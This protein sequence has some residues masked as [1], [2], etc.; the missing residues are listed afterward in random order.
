MEQ[1]ISHLKHEFET[2]FQNQVLVFAVILFIILLIPLLLRKLRLPG[3]IGLI[4]SGLIVGPH[5]LNWLEK[6]AAINLFSTIGLLYIMFIAGLEL[7]LEEFARNRHKSMLFGFFTFILPLAIGYPLCHY[8]LGY[9]VYTSLMTA[10]MFAT[11][12]LVAYPIVNRLGITKQEPVAIAVG[13]TI[14]VS[15]PDRSVTALV[16]VSEEG[17]TS[18]EGSL[19]AEVGV[20]PIALIQAGDRP[21]EV[22]EFLD[23]GLLQT[24]HS[25]DQSDYQDRGDQNQFG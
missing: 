5:G 20:G 4:L 2:P 23:D 12:T 17:G 22:V 18:A 6:N 16:V 19:A 7:E 8:L 25:G 3:I 1:F 14:S 24:S 21:A 13:G 11:H 9:N 15:V 10:G